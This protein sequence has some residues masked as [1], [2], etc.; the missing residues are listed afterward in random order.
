MHWVD[1]VSLGQSLD[2]DV[3]S[4]STDGQDVGDCIGAYFDRAVVVRKCVGLPLVSKE[5][6]EL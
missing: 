2:G 1:E 4:V 5:L 6:S 3:S